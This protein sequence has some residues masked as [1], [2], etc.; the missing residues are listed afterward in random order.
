M[1]N[2]K[3]NQM[4]TTNEQ[5]A[6]RFAYATSL[7]RGAEKIATAND[8]KSIAALPTFLLLGFSL[9]NAFASYLIANE[10]SNPGDYKSHDLIRAMEAC[11][12]TGLILSK[13][14]K[15][16]VEWQTPMQKDFAFRYPE[17]LDEISIPDLK[18]A[19]KLTREILIDVDTVL[20]T[21]GVNLSDIAEKL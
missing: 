7:L 3:S 6:F 1:T 21:K 5:L 17:K 4:R 15:A 19:C 20:R 2:Q 10:Y 16:F 13:Q 18:D 14:A 12:K 9:E 8:P 11:R